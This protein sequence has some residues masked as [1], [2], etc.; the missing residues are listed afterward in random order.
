MHLSIICS[1]D[2]RIL[3]PFDSLGTY[4]KMPG[5]PRFLFPE[6][7]KI[8]LPGLNFHAILASPSVQRRGG[9]NREFQGPFNVYDSRPVSEWESRSGPK[10][11]RSFPR[12]KRVETSNQGYRQYQRTCKLAWPRAKSAGWEHSCKLKTATHTKSAM[13]KRAVVS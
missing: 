1:P 6:Q 2:E 5:M 3:L 11:Q 9:S 4:T 13:T 12:E 8:L 7:E 10:Y